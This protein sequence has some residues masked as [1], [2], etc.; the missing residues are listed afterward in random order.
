MPSF[1]NPGY[2]GCAVH[3]LV[4]LGQQDGSEFPPI[5]CNIMA[6]YLT[7]LFTN[8]SQPLP[9]IPGA[10]AN[11]PRLQQS[12]PP[13]LCSPIIPALGQ[14]TGTLLRPPVPLKCAALSPAWPFPVLLHFTLPLP[15]LAS[16]FLPLWQ[17]TSPFFTFSFCLHSHPSPAGIM[18]LLGVLL[19]LVFWLIVVNPR[20]SLVV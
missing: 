17:E 2:T 5:C 7:V 20:T 15:S 4:S 9:L 1:P 3:L 18:D 16:P 13:F 14:K 12:Y 11:P 19:H 10:F 8:P 6:L